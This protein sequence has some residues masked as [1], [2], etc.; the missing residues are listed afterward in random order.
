MNLNLYSYRIT[1]LNPF[2]I[3]LTF[4]ALNIF[5]NIYKGTFLLLLVFFFG[6]LILG[7][8]IYKITFL[9]HDS[10]HSSLWK[11]KETNIL[12][13]RFSSFFLLVP[14]NIYKKKHLK[15]HA[16]KKI[17]EDPDKDNYW[18]SFFKNNNEYIIVKYS[19]IYKLKLWLLSPLIL[20]RSFNILSNLVFYP[21]KNKNKNSILNF[22]KKLIIPILNSLTLTTYIFA[23]SLIANKFFYVESNINIII[24][25]LF[26]YIISALSLSLMLGRWRTFAEHVGIN[27]D[28]IKKRLILYYKNEGI[29]TKSGNLSKI[30]MHDANFNIHEMHHRF[31]QIKSSKLIDFKKTKNF[32]K[33]LSKNL[34][35]E[36]PST[37]KKIT[38]IFLK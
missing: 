31:P 1:F 11:K 17:E 28:D 10:A 29:N 23:T 9:A 26:I 32:R 13:G 35:F 14:F 18:P 27:F 21:S 33:D 15:H 7:I 6:W 20:K 22:S 12:I 5:I 8:L 36:E 4:L 16:A 25:I 38:Q 34:Y 24:Y 2:L 37:L 19:E 30:L 3:G